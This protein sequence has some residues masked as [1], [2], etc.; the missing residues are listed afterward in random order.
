M[1]S[2][3]QIDAISGQLLYKARD[4]AIAQD[5]ILRRW[6]TANQDTIRFVFPLIMIPQFINIWLHHQKEIPENFY[7]FMITLLC[8][9]EVFVIAVGIYQKRTSLIKIEDGVVIFYGSAPWRK[10]G[11][12]MSEIDSVIF[13][14]N[15]SRWRG[16][17]QLSVRTYGAEHHVWLPIGKPSPISLIRQ[18]LFVNFGDKFIESEI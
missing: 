18:M 1:L 17:Y 12:L 3:K 11:F 15:P 14:K 9:L 5:S 7:Y 2:K 10:K 16:A 4:P 13:T 8:V 6:K